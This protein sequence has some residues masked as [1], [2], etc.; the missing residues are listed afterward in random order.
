MKKWKQRLVMILCLA[1]LVPMFSA[2]VPQQAQAGSNTYV[3]WHNSISSWDSSVKFPSA[4]AKIMV[5]QGQKFILS[6]YITVTSY[7]TKTW[8]ST[9]KTA[10]ELKGYKYSSSK[11]NVAS[12]S[13]KGVVNTKK[14]GTAKVTVKVPQRGSRPMVCTIQVVKKGSLTKKLKNSAQVNKE[15]AVIEKYSD[16]KIN[17][18]AV[19]AMHSSIANAHKLLTTDAYN[20]WDKAYSKMMKHEYGCIYDKNQKFNGFRKLVMPKY[21]TYLRVRSNL[22]AYV[23]KAKDLALKGSATITQNQTTGMF[24]LAAE[25]KTAELYKHFASGTVVAND[26]NRGPDSITERME[27]QKVFEVRVENEDYSSTTLELKLTPNSKKAS[28]SVKFPVSLGTYV[29][30]DENKGLK[31][32]VNPEPDA[33]TAQ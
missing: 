33:T 25:V 10:Y 20:S 15:L 13:K 12:I 6:D 4:A 3:Y 5:E 2:A 18:A 31:L 30:K 24:V 26:F 11:A 19:D 7:N 22:A 32:I 27:K 9:A 8:K 21:G 29:G 28:F 1:M 23:N 14:T 17:D 16:K